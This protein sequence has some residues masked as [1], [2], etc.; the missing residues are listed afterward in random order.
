MK[1]VITTLQAAVVVGV[2]SLVLIGVDRAIAFPP[3]PDQCCNVPG[4][5]AGTADMPAHCRYA[6]RMEIVDGLPFGDTI[7]IDAIIEVLACATLTGT[8]AT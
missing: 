1:L 8:P 2:A 3:P 7:Q 5:G 6:G 4:N